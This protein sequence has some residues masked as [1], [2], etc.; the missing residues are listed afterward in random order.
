VKLPYADRA[1]VPLPKITGYL[2]NE[3]HPQGRAKAAFFRRLG[4]RREQPEL[5][6]RALLQL[7]RTSDMTE[8][9]F[10]FGRKYAGVGM[11]NAPNGQRVRLLTVW[12]LRADQPP[13]V[14]LTAYPA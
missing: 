6:R 2:L 9:T 7:A 8:T 14:L 13:P 4:F 1:V 12:V 10:E 5:L 3:A 11:L